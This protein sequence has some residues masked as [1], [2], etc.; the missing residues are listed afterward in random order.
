MFWDAGYYGS[1]GGTAVSGPATRWYFAEGSQSMFDTY[2][3][4]AN[5]NAAAA[6]ATVQF[7]TEYDGVVTRTVPLPPTSRTNVVAGSDP[8]TRRQVVLDR[9][10]RHAAHHRGTRD[11]L[12]RPAG[13]AG[14]SRWA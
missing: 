11:V 8:R 14:T 1:H 10:G 12:R 13:R 6:T 5:A 7:L 3:L 4:L 9:R 2:V